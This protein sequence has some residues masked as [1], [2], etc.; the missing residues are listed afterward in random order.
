M[1]IGITKINLINNFKKYIMATIKLKNE[2][3]WATRKMFGRDNKFYNIFSVKGGHRSGLIT[4][5]LA[6]NNP[7]TVKVEIIEKYNNS[8]SLV[9]ALKKDLGMDYL[10]FSKN[11]YVRKDETFTVTYKPQSYEKKL[12][13]EYSFLQTKGKYVDFIVLNKDLK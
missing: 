10:Y 7:T 13:Q 4:H 5:Y 11:P 9:K 8:I 6:V 2:K 1:P 3:T 12:Y